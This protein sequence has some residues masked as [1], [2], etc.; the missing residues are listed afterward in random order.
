MN[1]SVLGDH[2]L[3]YTHLPI[4]GN[5]YRELPIRLADGVSLASTPYHAVARGAPEG[6]SSERH[7]G[8]G[9]W[10]YHGHGLGMGQCHVCL[11]MDSSL[12]SAMGR[13]Y[14]WVM[15]GALYLAKPIYTAIGGSFTYGTPEDGLLG[16]EPN[17]INHRSNIC[18]DSFFTC[19]ANDKPLLQYEKE[20]LTLA[21][22]LFLPIL[23][24][25]EQ[26]QQMP[27][28]Y[29]ALQRF[30]E[31]VLWER[32]HYASSSFS[33]LF[34]A[35][36]GF[37]GNPPRHHANRVP[38]RLGLFLSGIPSII[39][40]MPLTAQEIET[41]LKAIWD[42]HRP[43]GV[44]GYV[45]DIT[46]PGSSIKP[47]PARET[48]D[49]FDLM[50]ITRMA[51]VKMLLLEPNVFQEYNQ[52][53][54]PKKTDGVNDAKVRTEL[55]NNFFKNQHPSPKEL[56]AYTDLLPFSPQIPSSTAAVFAP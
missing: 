39:T 54:I 16:R 45:K 17:H 40:G 12:S 56:G 13:R 3:L 49:L 2:F 43:P 9:A 14:G 18:L 23:R 55:S 48:K 52:I 29:L 53:A 42:D 31:A 22:K 33:K 6:S 28:P 36:D 30:L 11:K 4:D 44:H 38:R 20:D 19:D 15:A 24:C 25:L 26:R 5:L 47:E 21:G 7:T 32:L 41:R 34:P 10:V 37:A 35:L 8:F 1:D 50:E 46:F 51:I 27:R